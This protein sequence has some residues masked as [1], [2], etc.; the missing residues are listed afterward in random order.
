MTA[1]FSKKPGFSTR[2]VIIIGGFNVNLLSDISLPV[3]RV[4][5][6]MRSYYLALVRN[7]A[8]RYL[9]EADKNLTLLD[10]IWNNFVCDI[11]SSGSIL[12]D[13]TGH[14]PFS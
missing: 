8:T 5:T 11:Y 13:E 12:H 4:T 9:P 1:I 2:K 10:H 6:F 3:Q 14:C 7:H